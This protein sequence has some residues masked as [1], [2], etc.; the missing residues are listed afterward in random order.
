MDDQISKE[1][2][3]IRVTGTAIRPGQMDFGLEVLIRIADIRGLEGS[4][5][6]PAELLPVGKPLPTDFW[7][8]PSIEELATAQDVHPLDDVSAIFGTWP[9][10]ESDGFEESIRALRYRSL[11]GGNRP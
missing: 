11:A 4:E 8:S 3:Q 7:R 5:D 9:G 1:L 6:T 10:E 2:L